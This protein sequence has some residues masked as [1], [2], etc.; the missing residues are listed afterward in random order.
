MAGVLFTPKRSL[1][2]SQYRPRRSEARSEF[3]GPGLR[4][5]TATKYSYGLETAS[6]HAGRL[7]RH[8]RSGAGVDV[9]S[10]RLEGK[11]V[12]C[13]LDGMCPCE[14]IGARRA[15]DHARRTAGRVSVASWLPRCVTTMSW[16]V[17]GGRALAWRVPACCRGPRGSGGIRHGVRRGQCGGGPGRGVD[18]LVVR[19][20][21]KGL[22]GELRRQ[23]RAGRVGAG[24]VLQR[25]GRHRV[26]R[27]GRCA[28]GA[29][30]LPVLPAQP[31]VGRGSVAQD[32]G[33]PCT[34]RP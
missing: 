1:V 12:G 34:S 6:R 26:T 30:R 4:R 16:W 11:V 32:P 10:C 19:A 33:F 20:G 3:N 29:G 23:L 25:A 24:H 7:R 8:P 5:C 17:P 21:R 18:R 15:L 31:L 22:E 13:S 27:P 28:V 14:V 9:Q 2:R